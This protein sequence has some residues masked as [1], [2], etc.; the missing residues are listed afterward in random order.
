MI[1]LKDILAE[2]NRVDTHFFVV[3]LK[4]APDY[5]QLLLQLS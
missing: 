3:C 4:I 2:L 5:F 1:V